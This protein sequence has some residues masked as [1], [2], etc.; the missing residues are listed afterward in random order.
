MKPALIKSLTLIINQILATGIFPDKLKIA[1]V[2]PIFKKGDSTQFGNYRPISLIPVIS[3]VIEKIIYAQ[4]DICLKT[5]NLLF[6]NQCG[7]RIEHTTEFA[8]L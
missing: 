5:Q 8:A 4:L 2:I 3:K 6:D 1:K 7:F